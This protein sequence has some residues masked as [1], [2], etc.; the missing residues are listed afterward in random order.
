MNVV[1]I[2]TFAGVF[3]L[4]GSAQDVRISVR[5]VPPEPFPP[6]SCTHSYSGAGYLHIE[7]DSK[8]PYRLSKE[9][10]GEYILSRL[11]QGYS[12]TLYPQAS[13]RIFSVTNCESG[14]AKASVPA[15]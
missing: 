5:E 7:G 8:E 15:R 11:G 10:I 9:Q 14:S 4:A 6:G 1:K 3:V 2:A 12:V 13:G